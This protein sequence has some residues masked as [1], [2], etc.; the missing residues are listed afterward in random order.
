MK[1][2]DPILNEELATDGGSG[3]E[4]WSLGTGDATLGLTRGRKTMGGS[5]MFRGRRRS[6]R[7]A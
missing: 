6:S 7:T 2:E 3:L 4:Q 5:T 1:K